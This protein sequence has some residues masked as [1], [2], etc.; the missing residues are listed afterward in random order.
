MLIAATS[1]ATPTVFWLCLHIFA[2]SELLESIR[3]EGTK[4]CTVLATKIGSGREATINATN[5]STACPVL[6]SAYQEVLRLKTNGALAH[7]IEEDTFLSD[8]NS[9]YLLKR[10]FKLQIPTKALH[11]SPEI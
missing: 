2:D 3:S 10:G 5:I 8:S 4:I 9:S 6:L 7:L 11:T 1:N